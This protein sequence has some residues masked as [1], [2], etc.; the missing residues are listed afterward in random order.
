MTDQEIIKILSEKSFPDSNFASKVKDAVGDKLNMQ[1]FDKLRSVCL[2]FFTD[3]VDENKKLK[4]AFANYNKSYENG[5]LD[6]I[7]IIKQKLPKFS[8]AVTEYTDYNGRKRYE[9]LPW[10]TVMGDVFDD[11][12]TI[13]QIK[14]IVKEEDK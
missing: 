3:F 14:E 11:N 5:F 1:D 7:E 9:A 4:R 13:K 2:R 12:W 8:H 10:E 6:A